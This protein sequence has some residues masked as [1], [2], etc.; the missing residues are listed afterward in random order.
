V[1]WKDLAYK[2]KPES[3]REA[4]RFAA[5]IDPHGLAVE[6]GEVDS[7]ED[8]LAMSAEYPCRL[9]GMKQDLA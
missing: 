7:R 2:T 5:R 3:Q 1:K 6:I 8:R 4:F 9:S